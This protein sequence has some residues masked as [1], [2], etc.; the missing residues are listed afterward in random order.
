MAK[1]IYQRLNSSPE[2]EKFNLV[3]QIKRSAI[4]APSNMRVQTGQLTKIVTDF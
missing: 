2:S 4:S 3:S 1:N